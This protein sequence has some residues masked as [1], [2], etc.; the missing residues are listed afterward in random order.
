[1]SM[2]EQI[3]LDIINYRRQKAHQLMC[4]VKVLMEHE[5]WNSTVNRLY[6]AC[7]HMISALLILY[8]IEVKTHLGVRQA[9]G[10]NFIKTRILTPEC[11]RIFTRLYDKRQSSDYDDFKEFTLEEVEDLYPQVQ[12]LLKEVDDVI[13]KFL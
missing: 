11:G 7:F 5:M 12:Y 13:A 6:Y 2:D 1:M 9:F 10:L 3:R 4:D 8:K